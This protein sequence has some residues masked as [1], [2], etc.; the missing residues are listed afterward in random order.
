MAAAAAA[1]PNNMSTPATGSECAEHVYLRTSLRARWCADLLQ[2][3]VNYLLCPDRH[4]D[5]FGM[6]CCVWNEIACC[7]RVTSHDDSPLMSTLDYSKR[8]ASVLTEI[9]RPA[10][11]RLETPPDTPHDFQSRLP[12]LPVV[13]GGSQRQNC[14]WNI[15]AET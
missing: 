9:P 10:P 14:R 6:K 7:S 15:P 4:G 5:A 3:I 2:K 8:R 1:A 12:F 11:L 13:D